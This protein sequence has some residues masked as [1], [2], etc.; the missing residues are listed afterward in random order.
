MPRRRHAHGG[1]K[2]PGNKQKRIKLRKLL[3]RIGFDFQDRRCRGLLA[4]LESALIKERIRSFSAGLNKIIVDQALA[5]LFD[6]A[7]EA[8]EHDP[9]HISDVMPGEFWSSIKQTVPWAQDLPG[10]TVF[11]LVVAL[12]TAQETYLQAHPYEKFAHGYGRLATSTRT[13]STLLQ[14]HHMDNYLLMSIY[15]DTSVALGDEADSSS[16]PE[17]DDIADAGVKRKREEEDEGDESEQPP[18]KRLEMGLGPWGLTEEE[19]ALAEDV[20]NMGME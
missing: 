13:F 7:T 20:E 11:K 8:M 10:S 12:L 16:E 9:D 6:K 5:V 4:G 19:A 15:Y 18:L 1:Y 2:F 3:P 17:N 14:K